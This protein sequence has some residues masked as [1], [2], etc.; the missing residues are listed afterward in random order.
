MTKGGVIIFCSLYNTNS[1]KIRV[2][3]NLETIAENIQFVYK[4][5]S[6]I[7]KP[8][9][10]LTYNENLKNCNY[11][12]LT[13]KQRFYFVD[14]IQFLNGGK[15]ML[16]LSVDVLMSFRGQIRQITNTVDRNENLKNAYLVDETYKAY[17]YNQITIKNFPSGLTED[18]II[19]MTVG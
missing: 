14:N 11:V 17:S 5:D 16:M 4:D 19:L 13:D 7:L 12:Y 6:D 9:I 18:S 8:S 3:K 10:I 15:I 2:D 1:E